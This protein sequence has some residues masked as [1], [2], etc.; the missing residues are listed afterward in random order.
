MCVSIKMDLYLL[1]IF[2]YYILP[3]ADIFLTVFSELLVTVTAT[4]IG[5]P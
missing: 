3:D 5:S 2:L 1:T 4:E